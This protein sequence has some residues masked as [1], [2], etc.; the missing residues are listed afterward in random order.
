MVPRGERRLERSK[1]KDWMERRGG[2]PCAVGRANRYTYRVM[3]VQVN[4][5][6]M[7]E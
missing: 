3:E 1:R 7:E 2:A 4:S 6:E 5:R